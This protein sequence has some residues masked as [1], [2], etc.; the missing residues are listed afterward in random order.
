M[1]GRGTMTM[2]TLLSAAC[3]AGLFLAVP[4]VHAQQSQPPL[5]TSEKPVTA[6]NTGLEPAHSPG[7]AT[8]GE[9]GQGRAPSEPTAKGQVEAHSETPHYPLVKPA[10]LSWSFAGPTGK[11]DVGQLQRGLKVYK[12]VCS[13]CHSLEL[14]A[15]RNLADLGYSENQVKAF[16]A[17][18]QIQDPNPSATGEMVERP[19]IP[20]DYFPSPYPN[21]EAAAAANNG[22]APPDLSL[23]AKARFVERGFP[24]FLIDIVTQYAE[25]G[26]DYVYSLLTGYGETPPDGVEIQPGTHYNPYFMA[27]PALA[28]AQPITEG[29]VTYDDGTPQTVEQYARDVSAFL[30]WTAEPHLVTRKATGLVVMIF[31][32][33]FAFMVWLVKRRVWAG[34]PH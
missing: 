1:A 17:E 23:M 26:P 10:E 11:W 2:K 30:M 7:A 8:S 9:T 19:G 14:V 31:L 25:G 12:E 21:A 34:I 6:P 4:P 5:P 22:A 20:S 24:L 32:V 29:Q 13:A 27:G 16:A 33:L 3:L 15:F 18:Y 28:M